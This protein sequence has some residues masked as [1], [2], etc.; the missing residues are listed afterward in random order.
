MPYENG[1]CLTVPK[2]TFFHIDIFYVFIL[3]QFYLAFLVPPSLYL[4]F[5]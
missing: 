5:V 3:F 1:K 2:Y 4:S